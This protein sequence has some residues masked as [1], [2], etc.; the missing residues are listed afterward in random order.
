MASEGKVAISRKQIGGE[1]PMV[2]SEVTNN[3][4]YSGFFGTLDSARMQTVTEKIISLLNATS[5]EIII[6]DLANVDMLDSAVANHLTR[7]GDTLKLIGVEVIFCGISGLLA[8]TMVTAGVT[9]E[10][11]RVSRDFKS[12]LKEAYKIQGLEVIDSSHLIRLQE[13]L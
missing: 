1:V 11:Y 2:V 4:L 9:F 12:G 5:I 10:N 7:L 13:K 8:N 3:T 6:L